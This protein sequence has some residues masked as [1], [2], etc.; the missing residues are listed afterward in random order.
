MTTVLVIIL[1]GAWVTAAVSFAVMGLL[2][3]W[4]SRHMAQAAHRMNM[5]F[6]RDDIFDVPSRYGFLLPMHTGHSAQANNVIYGR[7]GSLPFRAFDFRYEIGHGPRRQTRKYHVTVV[8][9][10]HGLPSLTLWSD[11][12]SQQAP[13]ESLPAQFHQGCWSCRG[14]EA[15]AQR[16]AKALADA[17]PEALSLQAAGNVLM[18]CAPLDRKEFSYERRCQQAQA[19]LKELAIDH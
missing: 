16:L 4:R 11:L 5:R 8:E 7:L 18:L 15:L 10:E 13:L 1:I 3:S 12:D 2:Q 9:T 17:P 6:S 19:A 14:D